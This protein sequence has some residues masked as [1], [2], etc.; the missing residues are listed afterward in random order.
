MTTLH[1]I[2]KELLTLPVYDAG[3]YTQKPYA[4]DSDVI[5]FIDFLIKNFDESK[6][7]FDWDSDYD[8]GVNSY[9]WSAPVVFEARY[10]KRRAG[11]EHVAISFHRA[12][13]VRC[14]Y[15][16][17]AVLDT[18][19]ESFL[20]IIFEFAIDIPCKDEAW[21]IA[22]RVT[23]ETGYVDAWNHDTG[24]SFEGYYESDDAPA[25]VREAVEEWY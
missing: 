18:D 16:G 15:T 19:R 22:Q 13:D 9:N 5:T 10:F 24:E 14:N 1:S 17:F 3:Y 12:G 11:R 6:I 23:S 4:R 7:R 21:S 2:K 8:D 25:A 20:Q